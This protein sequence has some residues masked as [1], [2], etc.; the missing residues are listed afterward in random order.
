MVERGP[1]KAGVGGSTPSLGTFPSIT[2]QAFFGRLTI[3]FPDFEDFCKE[4]ARRPGGPRHPAS[5]Y[6]CF[7]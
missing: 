7:G 3:R 6:R 1:E 5:V 2:W 4:S